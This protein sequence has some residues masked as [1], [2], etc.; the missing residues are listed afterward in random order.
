MVEIWE[1]KYYSEEYGLETNASFRYF[2]R[3]ITE[4]KPPFNL[5]ICAETFIKE[6]LD[7][8][9]ILI[10]TD[11]KYNSISAE[12]Q[13][14]YISKSEYDKKVK[15]RHNTLRTYSK[16]Y[17]YQL[18]FKKYYDYFVEQTHR[19]KMVLLSDWEN[20]EFPL[21]LK[22]TSFINDSL[23]KIHKDTEL[24]EDEKAKAEL[25][26]QRAYNEAVDTVYNMAHGG[27]KEYR[28]EHN[29]NL[30]FNQNVKIESEEEKLERYANY[31]KQI[32]EDIGDS[33]S[34]E[35]NK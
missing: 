20:G 25:N 33:T 12:L 31:F 8:K 3:I 28:T 18:R 11:E 2:Q 23:Q 17:A 5:R 16:K 15:S 9:N 29:G 32:K 27:K 7:R 13:L 35:L 10:L 34:E 6:E 14:N 4:F 19:N 21:A 24:T 22:R 26:N 30:D 1:E